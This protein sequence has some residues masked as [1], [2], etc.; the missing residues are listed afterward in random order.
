MLFFR[1]ELLP[2]R[3][4]IPADGVC[5]NIMI[6]PAHLTVS[7]WWESLAFGGILR[8]VALTR[9]TAMIATHHKNPCNAAWAVLLLLL[10]GSVCIA[11][12][13][14]LP[15]GAR[16]VA[17]GSSFAA[18]PGIE[19]QQATCGRSDHNYPHLVAAA[20]ALSL[21][22]VSCSGATTDNILDMPQGDAAPQLTAVTAD[23]RLVTVTIGGNDI[24]YSASTGRCS[25]ASPA[26][27]CTAR[28][29]QAAIAQA[30]AQLPAKLGAV[31]DA[32]RAKAPEAVIVVV[33]YPKVIP[34]RA[35]RCPALGLTDDD[36]DYLATLGEQLQT[37]LVNAANTH[38]A[39]LAD[40]YAASESHGPCADDSVR[41]INGASV[42]SSGATFHPTALAHEAMAALVVS[43]VSTAR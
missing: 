37:A 20:L 14:A 24:R 38:G 23:A 11:Q 27:R 31:L 32:I 6:D 36:A 7:R 17:L 10:T 1:A 8:A 25:G 43:A 13:A 40:P 9:S 41:W 29:D 4:N 2:E 39:L 19:Q 12:P 34:A 21:T 5:Y 3:A 18:G 35:Q 30:V 16:Y 26:D 42:A 33:A 15:A 28:I 22:D